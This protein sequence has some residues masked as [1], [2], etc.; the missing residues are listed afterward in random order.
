MWTFNCLVSYETIAI[1]N[2]VQN[3][4]FFAD[5]T[6]SA[7]YLGF[8]SSQGAAY[9]VC[10]DCDGSTGGLFDIVDGN[11]PSANGTEPPVRSTAD[12]LPEKLK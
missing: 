8:K 5:G 10:M 3:C 12:F 9:G 6:I 11:D 4:S 7:S 2:Y 1:N